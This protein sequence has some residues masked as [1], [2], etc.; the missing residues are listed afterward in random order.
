MLL[1]A[2]LTACYDEVVIHATAD[3][4]TDQ[5]V[6]TSR[7]V[8]LWREYVTCEDTATCAAALA[9]DVA[10]TRGAFVEKGATAVDAWLEVHEGK[11]DMVATWTL[12]LAAAT[13]DNQTFVLLK[14]GKGRG[15]LDPAARKPRLAFTFT[16]D[17]NTRVTVGSA[18]AGTRVW[19][20][21]D[22]PNRSGL[23]FPG[24]R[25]EV[26]VRFTTLDNEEKVAIGPAW[27]SN[28]SGLEEALR[29]KPGLVR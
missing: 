28:F 12:P 22:T 18:P 26:E 9:E 14:E 10:N 29:A 24:K 4:K 15:V 13:Y 23:V 17:T 8:N 27:I 1:L 11:L 2:L 7:V 21:P 20:L 25:A 6:G 3:L 16:E 5:V 19:T